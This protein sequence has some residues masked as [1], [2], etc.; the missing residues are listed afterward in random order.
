[1]SRRKRVYSKPERRD[2]RYD[3]SIVSKLVSKVMRQGKR[4]LAERIVYAAIDR[5]NEGAESVDP[6]EV[7]N[8]AV[9]NAKPRVEV[10]SRRVGGATYQVPLEVSPDRQEALAMRWI[11]N[12][13]RGR[14]GTPMHIA[15]ANEIRDASTNQGVVVRKRDETHKMA[16]A[17]RAFAHFRW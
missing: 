9:E 8:R 5:A 2:A 11:V 10:K 6:V 16:Q 1:M 7:L 15:L 3:S 12:A 17:N 4:S 14:R 13:A